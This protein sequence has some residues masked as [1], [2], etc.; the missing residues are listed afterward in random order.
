MGGVHTGKPVDMSM[1]RYMRRLVCNH[2]VCF[3]FYFLTFNLS[4]A[5]KLLIILF[6]NSFSL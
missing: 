5:F 1:W 6:I 4:V 3:F 2:L